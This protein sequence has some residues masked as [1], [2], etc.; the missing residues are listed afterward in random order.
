MIDLTA[1]L[2]E[3]SD[4]ALSIT[5]NKEDAAELWFDILQALYAIE[6]E[7]DMNGTHELEQILEEQSIEE[8]AEARGLGNKLES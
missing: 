7:D 2:R 5:S 6:R 8:F 3:A 1:A 4:F